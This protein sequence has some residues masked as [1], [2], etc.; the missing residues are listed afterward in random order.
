MKAGIIFTGTGPILILTTYESFDNSKFAEKL[1]VKGIKKFIAS[2]LPLEKVK[3]KYGNH[4]SVVM[5]DLNQTD[6][7][8]VLDYNG[9]NVFYNFSFS[10]MGKPIYHEL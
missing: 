10:D 9:Y 2:E 3:K 8:R 6:D 1:N 4:F 7:L 5:G